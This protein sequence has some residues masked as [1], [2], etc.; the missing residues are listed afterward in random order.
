MKLVILTWYRIWHI[1]IFLI[2]FCI[3]LLL[4][5]AHITINVSTMLV[6][7]ICMLKTSENSFKCFPVYDCLPFLYRCWWFLNRPRYWSVLWRWSRPWCSYTCWSCSRCRPSTWG[8]SG[9]RATWRQ[10]P[11][12]TRRCATD[13]MMTGPTETV[14]TLDLFFLFSIY[15]K[16]L[17][18]HNQNCYTTEC[19]IKGLP[20]MN[21]SIESTEIWASLIILLDKDLLLY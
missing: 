8:D 11:P 21:Q 18:A 13:S 15:A 7:S 9:G 20:V 14:C 17:M 1:I 19:F 3:V 16:C 10:C 6:H 2:A 5:L 12:S 4:D